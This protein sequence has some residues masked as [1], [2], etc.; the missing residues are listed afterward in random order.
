MTRK[1]ISELPQGV[2]VDCLE[3]RPSLFWVGI[4]LHS[5]WTPAPEHLDRMRRKTRHMLSARRSS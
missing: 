5:R 3:P 4:C 1:T 2:V